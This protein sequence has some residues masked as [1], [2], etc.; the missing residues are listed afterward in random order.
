MAI[1]IDLV[2]TARRRN[3]RYASFNSLM[4]SR[5]AVPLAMNA[6]PRN[7]HELHVD[8][9]SEYGKRAIVPGV[10]KELNLDIP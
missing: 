6:Q 4:P 1:V 2:L 10:L 5:P 3:V 9:G 7:P 8:R